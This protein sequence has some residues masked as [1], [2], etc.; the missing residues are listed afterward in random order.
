MTQNLYYSVYY[1][2]RYRTEYTP[3]R[4]VPFALLEGQTIIGVMDT[5]RGIYFCFGI[6]A[7]DEKN[8]E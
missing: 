4:E 3:R 6:D 2:R 8:Y 5:T 1:A 7:M